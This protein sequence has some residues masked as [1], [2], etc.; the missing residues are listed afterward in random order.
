MNLP[1][2]KS[3]L[4]I[5]FSSMLLACFDTQP[6]DNS[7]AE[8]APSAEKTPGI[9]PTPEIEQPPEAKQTPEAETAKI[10]EAELQRLIQTLP[11][12]ATELPYEAPASNFS[13]EEPFYFHAKIL[14]AW[15]TINASNGQISGIPAITDKGISIFTLYLTK[16]AITA[17]TNGVIN[18][19]DG[20]SYLASTAIGFYDHQFGGANRVLRNDL[21]GQVEGEVQFM[22]SHNVRPNGNFQR[23]TGDET[24]SIYSPRLVALREALVFFTP[25]NIENVQSIDAVLSLNGEIQ[26]TLSMLHPND[27]YAADYNG[28]TNVVF[29][30]K[31]LSSALPWQYV[32]NGLSI[33]F[34]INKNTAT[35]A[36]GEIAAANIDIGEATQV[37]FQSIRLGMLT[38]VD[39]KSGHYTLNNPIL[40]A[41]D[42]FQTIPTSRLIMGSYADM[43]LDKVIVRSGVIYDDA[44]P[45]TGSYYAGDMR[46]DVAKS[47]VS[48]GIN[49][50]NFGITS[51]NMNQSYPHLFKQTT[52]HHAWGNYENGRIPY[53]RDAM[54]GGSSN[55]GFS[56]YTHHTA[57]SARFIQNHLERYPLPTTE[58]ASGYKKW[59]EERGQYEEFNYPESEKRLMAVE[60]T[61]LNE[62]FES[63]AGAKLVDLTS[64]E[65]AQLDSYTSTEVQSIFSAT[66]YS[67]YQKYM[68]IRTTLDQLKILLAT[69]TIEGMS[70]SEQAAKVREL[71]SNN[72]LLA[73]SIELPRAG[74]FIQGPKYFGALDSSNNNLITPANTEEEASTLIAPTER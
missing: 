10:L 46:G 38:H 5:F 7:D 37:A 61:Q 60:L 20:S 59:N 25:T 12:A 8:Q 65:Q 49:L 21:F 41:T 52:I 44:S 17:E 71:L 54:S 27:T 42:Y 3:F 14:P 64:S 4:I 43:Q 18:V 58:F 50:A 32:K 31:A 68:S 22:Q 57:Y 6:T 51:N 34:I 11:N 36:L 45:T 48:V 29:S 55:T 67:E 56:V 72:D 26:T 24:I 69:M 66:A 28:N 33:R 16:G 62:I 70:D 1:C 19:Y 15:A 35:E 73:T 23:D 40:A 9:D 2:V 74:K 63:Q 13:E 47:Q 30:N 53:G 39:I